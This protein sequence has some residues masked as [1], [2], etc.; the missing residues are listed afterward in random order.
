V[1]PTATARQL[2]DPFV[3][4]VREDPGLRVDR[5]A[6]QSSARVARSDADRFSAV[7]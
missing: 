4:A 1:Q 5:L 3:F 6:A 2:L 7:A